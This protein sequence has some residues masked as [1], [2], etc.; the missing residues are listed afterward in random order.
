MQKERGNYN[1][2]GEGIRRT[3]ISLHVSSLYESKRVFESLDNSLDCLHRGWLD[4]SN[5]S[6]PQSSRPAVAG[7]TTI[8]CTFIYIQR[9]SELL[10]CR[11]CEV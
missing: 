6:R 11:C 10:V 4:Q 5:Q 7:G 9:Q 3:D 2:R 8:R 1:D